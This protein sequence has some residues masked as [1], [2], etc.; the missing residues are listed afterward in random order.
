MEPASQKFF[1]M[2]ITSHVYYER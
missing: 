1:E 2:I